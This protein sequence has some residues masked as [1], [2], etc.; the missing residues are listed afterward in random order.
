MIRAARAVVAITFAT[1]AFSS[2]SRA[3]APATGASV[4]S[5]RI[6]VPDGSVLTGRYRD[7]GRGT[8]GVL[9]FPMCGPNAADGWTPVADRLR[10]AGVSSLLVAEPGFG[11]NGAREARADAALAYLRSRLGENAPV[12]VTGGSCGVALALGTASRHPERVRAV[13]VVSGPYGDDHLD[14]VRRTPALAVFG[15]ASEGEPPSPEWARALKQA[16][17]NPASRVEVWTTR[18]HGT[19]YF[20]VNPAFAARI[21]DWLVER[22]SGPSSR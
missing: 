12:A 13:V 14:H 10:A 1:L 4:E 5:V 20:A 6:A 16:S 11:P 8:P 3:Q 22:L 19:E 21:T 7:A 17:A 18:A 15:G 2:A 9:L